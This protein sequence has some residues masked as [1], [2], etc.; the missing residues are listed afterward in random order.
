MRQ[1]FWILCIGIRLSICGV[2]AV[3]M[4]GYVD[5]SK[6]HMSE[7]C[8]QA[9]QVRMQQRCQPPGFYPGK[10]HVSISPRSETLVTYIVNRSTPFKKFRRYTTIPPLSSPPLLLLSTASVTRLLE[11]PTFLLAAAR[12]QQ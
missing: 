2:Q 7:A 10:G 12:L 1:Y 6:S 5:P 4:Y 8:R 9:L 3:S 11:A